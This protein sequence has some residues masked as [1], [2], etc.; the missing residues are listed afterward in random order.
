M[1]V[2]TSFHDDGTGHYQKNTHRLRLHFTH[3]LSPQSTL[4]HRVKHRGPRSHPEVLGGSPHGSYSPA[5]N[6]AKAAGRCRRRLGKNR[7]ELDRS[8]TRRTDRMVDNGWSCGKTIRHHYQSLSIHMNYFHHHV[9]NGFSRCFYHLNYQRWCLH[10]SF[11]R[12]Q[13]WWRWVPW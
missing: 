4:L 1:W 13:G 7:S 2:S 12:R 10:F 3:K 6:A 11:C 5:P 9:G 8:M